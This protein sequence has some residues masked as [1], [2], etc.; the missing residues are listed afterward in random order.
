MREETWFLALVREFSGMYHFYNLSPGHKLW[1][2]NVVTRISPREK[3]KGAEKITS[4]GM[5]NGIHTCCGKWL[6]RWSYFRLVF[7]LIRVV[8]SCLMCKLVFDF[9]RCGT[10]AKFIKIKLTENFEKKSGSYRLAGYCKWLQ[11]NGWKLLFLR[12]DVNYKLNLN[13][14][15]DHYTFLILGTL[16]TFI[17]K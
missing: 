17:A 14:S 12:Y 8:R 2:E 11:V 3:W 13:I 1:D 16:N 5:I 7:L 6:Y 15:T 9:R 4:S 10:V